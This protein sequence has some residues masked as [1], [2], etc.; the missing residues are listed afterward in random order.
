M[1]RIGGVIVSHGQLANELLAAAETVVGDI[2]HII[3]V[4]I[5]W[6]DDVEMARDEVERAIRS[7][8]K[9]TGVI[10]LTDMFGGTPTNIAAMFLSPGDVEIV[11][12]V[13]LPMVIKLAS[14][15]KD[16]DLIDLA[17]EIEDQG[18]TSIYRTSALLEP[19]KLKKDA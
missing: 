9:G 15:T 1:E 8:S 19:Q 5:G 7:V 10:I 3:A 16:L 2:G 17:K 12:G 6:H 14:N 4:S 18:K 11:T 13:N